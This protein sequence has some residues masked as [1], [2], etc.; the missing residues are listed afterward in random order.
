MDRF[1]NKVDK[2]NG[3]WTW[4]GYLDKDGYG[5]FLFNGKLIRAH[6]FSWILEH[7]E[8]S[9]KKLYVCHHCDN[10]PCVRPDHLFL[11]TNQDNMLDMIKKGLMF[12]RG[13]R[14][15]Q[16]KLKEEQV[17]KIREMYSTGEYSQQKIASIFGVNQTLIGFIVRR[18]KWQHI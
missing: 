5:N 4:K 9:D 16:A 14:N 12:W 2:K 17:L 7:G 1:W 8:I 18:V 13:S 3:C 6:R 15:S 10:P 11:G